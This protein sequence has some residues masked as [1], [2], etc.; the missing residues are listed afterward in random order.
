MLGRSGGSQSVADVIASENA[1][2][3]GSPGAIQAAPRFIDPAN[4]GDDRDQ[5]PPQHGFA[6]REAH[7]L[8][9]NRRKRAYDAQELV[10]TELA[11]LRTNAFTRAA[12]GALE[13]AALR[14][15]EPKV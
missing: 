3:G 6:A 4:A 15:R 14:Q 11:L 8:D 2:L 5:V 1:S 7:L 13:G 10:A 12:I 9:A